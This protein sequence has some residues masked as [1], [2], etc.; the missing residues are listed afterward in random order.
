MFSYFF[1]IARLSPHDGVSKPSKVQIQILY[2]VHIKMQFVP[3]VKRLRRLRL[4]PITLFLTGLYQR[5]LW[6]MQLWGFWIL[7][8]SA[9]C[10]TTNLQ[11]RRKLTT[12]PILATLIWSTLQRHCITGWTLPVLFWG[13]KIEFTENRYFGRIFEIK[14]SWSKFDDKAQ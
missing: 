14:I 5:A 13:P 11:Y 3:L 10:L 8:V 9:S 1:E 7:V 12:S 4:H 2:C 6:Q